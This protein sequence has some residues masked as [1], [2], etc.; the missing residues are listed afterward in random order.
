MRKIVLG[1]LLLLLPL[2]NAFT[3]NRPALS[4]ETREFVS[5]DAP[6][7]ALTH[8][9]VIDGTG[10]PAVADQTIVISAGKIQSIGP[11]SDAKTPEGAK[12]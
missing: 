2:G 7:V 9:R 3:Q 4:Q 11:A 12:V 8:V 10:A 6:S 1:I 5:V